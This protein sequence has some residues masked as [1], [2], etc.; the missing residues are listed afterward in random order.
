MHT[1]LPR[2]SLS[3]F[4][5][6]TTIRKFLGSSMTRWSCN[7]DSYCVYMKVVGCM[8]WYLLKS[9]WNVHCTD[10]KVRVGNEISLGKF[11][12]TDSKRNFAKKLVLQNSQNNKMFCPYLKS[13]FFWH[14]FLNFWLQLCLFVCIYFGSTEQNSEM[15]SLLRKGSEQNSESLILF[16]FHGIQSCVLSVDIIFDIWWL[17][18]KLLYMLNFQNC[19]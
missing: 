15:F 3:E 12:G 17:L 11:C 5:L 8:I 18:C 14:Y 2:T 1:L 4:P 10:F 13:L 9:T 6:C 19:E 16:L 7:S